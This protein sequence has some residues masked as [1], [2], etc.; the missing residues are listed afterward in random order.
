MAS[1]ASLSIKSFLEVGQV[2]PAD[3]SVL[4]RANHGV[5]KSQVIRQLAQRLGL[6]L[7]DRR[8]SQM[9][10][11]DIIGLPSTDGNVTR[12]NP[13]DWFLEACRSPRALFLDEINRGTP[14]V[15][16][17]CFQI[18][19]DR[20]LNG[21][22]LHPDTRVYAAVNIGS[23]YTVNEM[24]PAFLD[25][26]WAVDLAPTV[27]DWV[28][29][30]RGNLPDVMVDFIAQNERW[31]DTPKNVNPGDV[32]VSRRSWEKYGRALQTANL[33][34]K[35]DD[36]LFYAMGVGYV[37]VEATSAFK[38]FAKSVEGRFTGEQIINEYDVIRPRLKKLRSQDR[39][40]VAIEKAGDF[41]TGLDRL[42]DTQITNVRNFAKDLT[43]ELRVALWS[44]LVAKGV[45]KI[46]IA[47]GVH[48]AMK[49]LVVEA[50][51]ADKAE[52]DKKA[53]KKGA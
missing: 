11:G 1:A 15:Q 30:G 46:E 29:W 13:V 43:P 33:A 25:R 52:K 14:E 19:L 36:Q 26:F 45:E 5:G 51:A 16:Q 40:N 37:G 49:D 53:T 2:L 47:Q 7:I 17:A 31:L 34:D 18:V 22:K 38:D 44:R 42:N 39:W 12:F 23:A 4:L 48:K 41:V 50:F 28:A 3:T 32:S 20:E 10:E 9:T 8:V 35:C 27:E 21:H 24:D 6:T